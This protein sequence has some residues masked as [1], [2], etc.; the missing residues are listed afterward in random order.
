MAEP[1]DGAS[2]APARV[3]GPRCI[4]LV[5]P[6][7]SGKTTLLESLLWVTGRIGRK[8]GV[9]QKNSVGD[10]SPEARAHAMSVEL[11]VATADYLGDSYTFLDCPGSIEFL[12]E[13]FEAL[14]AADAAIVVCEPDPAKAPMLRPYLKHLEDA[15]IPHLLFVNKIETA[16]GQGRIRDLLEG[17]QGASGRPLILRQLPIREGGAVTGFYDL[18]L[19]RAYVYRDH[20]PSEVVELPADLSER[21]SEA[22]FEMLERIAD[23][24]DHLMEE[25]LS[26]IDPPREEVLTD[27]A[28]ELAEDQIV[29]VLLGSAEHD[30]GVRRLLKALRH[31]APP[32]AHTAERLG[33]DGQPGPLALVLKTSHAGQGGKISVARILRGAVHD[34]DTVYSEH[35]GG[36]IGGLFRLCGQETQKLGEAREGEVVGL[37]RLDGIA[38]GDVVSTAKAGATVLPHADGIS[39]VYALA[40]T[41]RDR[42]DEVK[43]TSALAKLC[44]EDRSLIFDHT[45]DTHEMLLRGQGE[46]HLRVAAERLKSRYGLD[47]DLRRPKVAYR[48]TIRKGTAHRYRHKRQTGGHGQFGDV[49]LEIAPLPRGSGFTFSDRITGGVV[50][51]QY[52]PAVEAGVRDALQQGP[53]GFPVIDVTVALTDGSFHTVD[54]SDM[55]FRT[56]ARQCVVDALPQC[57]PVLLEPILHIEIAVPST[58]TARVNGIVSSRRGQILGFDAR[59]GWPGWDIV[60]AQ[61][62]E[63][64][65][66]D[67]IVEL[68][69]AS[70]GAASFTCRFDHLS[71]LSGKLAD[72]VV[73]TAHAA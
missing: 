51:R 59:P 65:I 53:L 71:E 25:L 62:P 5:G 7:L 17:L 58:A 20:A 69:S 66:H 35:G 13:T 61:I 40:L 27:L 6:Y 10:A 72:Q 16:E 49:A 43:L 30:N 24:D 38:T 48:E 52:I 4:A 2:A 44:E 9:G 29:P 54:S 70:Q 67:L 1:R 64:E 8:G 37:G 15:G 28:R 63:V 68:R 11:N 14:S 60:V 42:K 26:D 57:G 18:A 34:G 47:L 23:H 36:R 73:A 39:P 56:A 55:A 33:I 41:V 46:V 22:R 45:A 12:Q 21:R 19:D 31:E 3:A 50:P 32:V